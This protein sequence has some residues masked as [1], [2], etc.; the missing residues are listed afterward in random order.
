MKKILF[1]IDSLNI[2]GA[3]RSLI[4]FLNLLNYSKFNIDLQLFQYNG[5]LEPYLTKR[6]NKLKPLYITEYLNSSLK[7][8]IKKPKLFFKRMIFSFLIRLKR[9]SIN[10]IARIYWLYLGKCIKASN[11]Y[12][13]IAIA[14]G[15]RIPTYYVMEKIKAQK[16]ICWINIDHKPQNKNL[17]FERVFYHDADKIIT[18]SSAVHNLLSKDIF[19]EYKNKMM[20][21][22]DPIDHHFIYKLAYE[23]IEFNPTN[24]SD[25]LILTVSRL[26]KNQKGLDIALQT[27]LI[28]KN[29]NIKFKWLVLGEGEYRNLLN[30]DLSANGL[31]ENFILMGAKINPYPYYKIC[32]VYV[33]TSRHEGYGIS[34]EEAKLFNKPIVITNFNTAELLIKNNINGIISSFNPVD[35]A[36]G[37]LKYKNDIKFKNYII[38]NLEKEKK[39]NLFPLFQLQELIE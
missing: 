8:Q 12:Y 30:N 15:Q 27:A 18:V 1:V 35:I 17:K 10:D 29:K 14:Y 2:G 38:S 9:R 25:L 31:E 13:D 11:N 33:Q 16:K 34:I 23:S 37:I 19:P 20:V 39:G 4:T 36:N 28:L 21:I 32:D 3:E 26:N 7:N 5:K 6:V 24:R 22:N